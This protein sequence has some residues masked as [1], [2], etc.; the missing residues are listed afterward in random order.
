MEVKDIAGRIATEF[1]DAF[2]VH[3]DIRGS[4]FVSRM[5]QSLIQEE[6]ELACTIEEVVQAAAREVRPD[7][8]KS[9]HL[10]PTI[11]ATVRAV[12]REKYGAPD[13]S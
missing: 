10:G 5:V 12:L 4:G 7:L 6:R 13:A 9:P 11:L 1:V 8:I 2:R 3:E